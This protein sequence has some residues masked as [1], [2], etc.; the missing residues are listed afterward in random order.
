MNHAT[1]NLYSTMA[2]RNKK[3][4]EDED[5]IVFYENGEE[6]CLWGLFK[7]GHA[8]CT[9]CDTEE[10]VHVTYPKYADL[11]DEQIEDIED[12]TM[13]PLES[14]FDI[15]LLYGEIQK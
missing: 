6:R 13:R 4:Y 1:I 15:A 10:E 11:T 8:V 3:L 5:E 7:D 2:K 9:D 12:V 14:Y